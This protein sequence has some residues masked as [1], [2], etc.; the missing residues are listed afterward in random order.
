VTDPPALQA[1]YLLTGGDRPK[2]ELA[3]ARLRRRFEDE[4]IDLVSALETPA[5]DVVALCNA[6]NLFGAAKLVVVDS[7]DG[8]PNADNRLTGGWKAAEIVVVVDYLASPAPGTTLA[9]VAAELKADS[10]LGKACK[11]VGDVLEYGVAKGKQAAWVAGRLR[12]VAP[13]RRSGHAPAGSRDR[14]ADRM[15]RRRAG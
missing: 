15:V 9:L 5:E 3:L 1:A 4:T 7:V 8:R 12:H 13:S 2:I 11:K 6:G 10:P 14:Q